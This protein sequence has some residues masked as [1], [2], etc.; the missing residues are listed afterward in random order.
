VQKAILA[1]LAALNGIQTERLL[2]P[3]GAG[4]EHGD[5]D[6]VVLGNGSNEL[7]ELLVR[8]F[9]R[10]GDEAVVPHPSFVVYPMIVQRPAACASW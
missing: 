1:A 6:Q 5:A 9:L 4:Q 2:P 8:S 7:I 10:P 3:A